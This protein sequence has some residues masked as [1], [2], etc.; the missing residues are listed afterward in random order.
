MMISKD[1]KIIFYDEIMLSIVNNVDPEDSG[2]N[3]DG[4][5]TTVLWYLLK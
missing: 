1:I 3:F 4:I 2:C 5:E